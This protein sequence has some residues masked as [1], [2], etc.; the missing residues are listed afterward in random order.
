[1]A[2]RTPSDLVATLDADVRRAGASWVCGLALVGLGVLLL[3]HNLGW[4]S[5]GPHAWALLILVPALGAATTAVALYRHAGDEASPAVVGS[6]TTA[7]VLAFISAMLLFD[8]PWSILWPMFLIIPGLVGL[9]SCL[10]AN[11]RE[12]A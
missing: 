3:L 6:A 11:V 2:L 9:F 10:Q 12:P 5:F 1:M 7:A 8:L 4:W